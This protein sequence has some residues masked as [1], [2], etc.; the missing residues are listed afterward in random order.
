MDVTINTVCTFPSS[1]NGHQQHSDAIS[2]ELEISNKDIVNKQRVVKIDTDA[3]FK[4][5]PLIA[6]TLPNNELQAKVSDGT[7]IDIKVFNFKLRV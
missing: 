2:N 3:N 1:S 7:V 5:S 4:T 6:P